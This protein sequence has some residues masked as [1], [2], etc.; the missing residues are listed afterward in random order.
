[1]IFQADCMRV[2]PT[3]AAQSVDM[4][5]A[6]LPYGVTRCAWDSVLPLPELWAQYK[7]I[8]KPGG[9]IALTATQPFASQLVMS[10]GGWFRYDLI[11]CKT[12]SSGFLNANKMPL[13][14]HESVLIFNDRLPTYNPQKTPGAAYVAR[15]RGGSIKSVYD[16]TTERNDTISNGERFPLSYLTFKNERGLHPT[17]KPVALFEWLIKTY[18]NPGELVLDNCAGSGTTGVAALNTGRRFILIER[19]RSYVNTILSRLGN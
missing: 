10:C 11:W 2:L 13:R 18:T 17:Q 16:T 15:R 4:I 14:A 6:D 3:L 7:R 8:I 12:H 9:V 1:M 5:L 19:E